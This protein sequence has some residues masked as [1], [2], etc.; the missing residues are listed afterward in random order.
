MESK[1][2]GDIAGIGASYHQLGRIT[3]EQ[4]KYIESVNDVAFMERLIKREFKNNF[5]LVK[6]T[7]WFRGECGKMKD[8]IH[9]IIHE[10]DPKVPKSKTKPAITKDK[11]KTPG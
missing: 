1:K 8:I 2:D 11:N 9:K 6:G 10:N 4:Q 5:T 3:F 7:E